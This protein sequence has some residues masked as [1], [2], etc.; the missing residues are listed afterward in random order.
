MTNLVEAGGV[1]RNYRQNLG[2]AGD[3][4]CIVSGQNFCNFLMIGMTLVV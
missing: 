3:N 4:L 1:H 2:A